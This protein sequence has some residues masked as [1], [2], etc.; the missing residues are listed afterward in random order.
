MISAK[1]IRDVMNFK[2]ITIAI[3]NPVDSTREGVDAD[4]NPWSTT[5]L[6]PYGYILGTRGVDNDGVDCFV[7]GNLL[8]DKVF[9]IHQTDGKDNYDEDKCMLGF[10]NKE[11]ARDAYL[12]HYDS[13]SFLGEITEMP[14]FEFKELLKTKGQEGQTI[15]VKR[16]NNEK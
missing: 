6:Y 12:A 10:D 15:D 14:F 5:F 1:G 4:G 7:G 3:E 11:Q 16:F 8:S 2:G 9:I 13:Q